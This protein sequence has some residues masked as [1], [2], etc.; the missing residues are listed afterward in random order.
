MTKNNT[1]ESMEVGMEC[2]NRGISGYQLLCEAMEE[3]N[4]AHNQ[5]IRLRTI[6]SSFK[7]T[8][9][10]WQRERLEWIERETQ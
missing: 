6:I 2:L 4:R 7:D 10:P 8:L 3:R 5:I 9:E 1:T